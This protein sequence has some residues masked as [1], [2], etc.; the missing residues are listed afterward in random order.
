MPEIRRC[1]WGRMDETYIRYHDEEWGR[2]VRDD[3]KQFEF[4]VLESAQAGLSWSTILKKRESYRRLYDGF[5]P[6]KVALYDRKRVEMMLSDPGIIRNRRKIE[7]SVNNA[8]RFLEVVKEFG[9]FS[10]Y[11]WGFNQGE[12]V[13]NRFHRISEIPATS[14]LSDQAAADMKKRGFTFL[15][16]IVLYAHM[17][18]LGLVNDHLVS[19]FRYTECM[20]KQPI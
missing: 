14:P 9:S 15:G 7:A 1:D 4:L 3:R 5:D 20:D 10:N 11:L 12:Q 19:C 2:P 6:V 13:V 16:S 18:A 17:Q 8:R